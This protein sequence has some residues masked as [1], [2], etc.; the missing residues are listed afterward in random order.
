MPGLSFSAHVRRTK[1]EPIWI[2]P[3]MKWVVAAA[4]ISLPLSASQVQ[5]LIYSGFMTDYTQL[6]KVTVGTF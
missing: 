1:C 3:T 5:E 4:C 6:R 2:G